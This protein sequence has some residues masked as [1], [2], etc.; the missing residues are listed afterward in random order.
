MFRRKRLTALILPAILLACAGLAGMFGGRVH[1]Q[2]SVGQDI[3]TFANMYSLV[4]TNAATAPTADKAIYEGAIPGM[5]RTLDPHSTFFDPKAYKLLREDQ[6]GHY[7]GV[8]MQVTPRN[9]QT[10][11][12]W[13]FPGSPAYRA[14]IRPGDVIS[15]VNDKSTQGLTT[16]EVADMLKGPRNSKVK[17]TVSRQGAKDYLTFN[18]IRQ[19]INR[20]TVTGF[21]IKPGYAYVKIASFGENTSHE[22]D[23]TL[24]NLGEDRVKGLVLDL[25]GNPGGLL[26]EAVAV[27]DR[28]L[29]RGQVVVSQ[30]G[31]SSPERVY[32]AAHGN[33]GRDYP[34]VVVVNQ[35]SASA[36]EIV[37]GAL[38]DHDRGWIL[39]ETTFGKGLVQTVMPLP[40]NT[41]LALTTAHFYTPSGRLIQRDYSHIS[42]Y[43]YY[44]HKDGV[45]KDLKDIKTTDSGRTVYGGGGITPDE[46]FKPTPFDSLEVQL[47]RKGLFDFSRQYFAAHPD[48][49]FTSGWM[50]DDAMLKQLRDYLHSNG[51]KFEDSEFQKDSEWIK[52]YLAKEMYISGVNVDESNRI[53]EATD[54]EVMAAVTAM[55]KAEAL[56][57]R[58]HKVMAERGR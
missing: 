33:R 11:V 4:E 25:R 43:D 24:R 28:F 27:C 47:Y 45:Q 18:V 41:A 50:P 49:Q 6:E 46:T 34:I 39:G 23:E 37:S 51:Y 13:P 35:S 48:Q 21:W 3:R 1:A 57:D 29:R 20:P 7:S 31:R 26:T 10:V 38:Q 16:T 36:A 5:L 55:P 9:D 54:P 44:S 15:F 8:G 12:M 2:N 14:G 17:I 53:F 58:A 42:F 22:L 19:D 52:R 30:H 32:R 56:L 40:D